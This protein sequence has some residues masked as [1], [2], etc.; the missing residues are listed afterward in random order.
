MTVAFER[1]GFRYPDRDEW[2]LTDETWSVGEG[3]LALVTGPSGSGKSTLLRCVNGLVPHFSGGE[4]RGRVMVAGLDTREHGPRRM[5][6]TVGFVFQDPDAQ[7]VA[8]TV[9]DEL[10][11]GMEQHG[12]PREKMVQRIE[13]TLDQLSLRHLRGR[14]IATLS[15]GERQ[16]V[17][18]GAAVAVEPRILVLDEPLSQ[19]D[20]ESI[21]EVINTIR[22]L[23]ED[24]MTVVV[25]EHRVDRLIGMAG[26]VRQM[27]ERVGGISFGATGSEGQETGSAAD[28]G[29]LEGFSPTYGG[30]VAGAKVRV[31]NADLGIGKRVVLTGVSVEIGSGEVVALVGA[32]GSGKTTL[33][34]S[35]LG[36]LP[37]L[38]G[39]VEIET[40]GKGVAYLPQRAGSV[41][42]NETVGGE[43]AFTRR[44]NP[45]APDPAWLVDAL[46][47]EPLIDFDPRDL[48]AGERERAALAAV[49]AASPALALLDEP[50]RGMDWRRK[51][52][53]ARMLRRLAGAGATV[54]VA[55]HDADLV[56]RAA[57]RVVRL[58]AGRVVEESAPSKLDGSR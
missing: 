54:V 51:V 23:H 1:V 31:K 8:P 7:H 21:D 22:A 5:S 12:W 47:L 15:G 19:L 40:G 26:R 50:T 24:G 17:A 37:P 32:N 49:L 44:V 53:L 25:A 28:H 20:R 10:A 2:A 48:S 55:T 29:A 56:A 36:A 14:S 58:E 57:T 18:I 27:G 9:E 43:I 42:F 52:I 34:R 3:E 45:A 16:R 39:L 38:S 46:E 33:L 13:R 41:L 35:L 30:S 11:F 4:L 6:R